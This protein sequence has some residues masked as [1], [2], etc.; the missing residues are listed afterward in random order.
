MAIVPIDPNNGY[1]TFGSDAVAPRYPLYNAESI[2]DSLHATWPSRTIN[3]SNN[4][5]FDLP[6]IGMNHVHPIISTHENHLLFEPNY[7]QYNENGNGQDWVIN[8]EDPVEIRKF[9]IS[10]A[11]KA[12]SPESLIYLSDASIEANLWNNVIKH[13]N[14]FISVRA[15]LV[16]VDEQYRLSEL[17]I[18]R[19]NGHAKVVAQKT[20]HPR[21]VVDLEFQNVIIPTDQVLVLLLDV[22]WNSSVV[23]YYEQF[24]T[25]PGFSEI[26]YKYY[27]NYNYFA[28]MIILHPAEEDSTEE[29]Y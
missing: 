26:A 9:N 24:G 25:H 20:F 12:I 1:Y 17:N 28:D 4:L 29:F 22:N 2:N 10:L 8:Q 5:I 19:M 3:Q 7:L 11:F 14:C 15:T 27:V 23:A 18:M 21:N 6:N 16:V 13:L